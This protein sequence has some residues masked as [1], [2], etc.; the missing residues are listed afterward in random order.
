MPD[1]P[2]T[3]EP[4]THAGPAYAVPLPYGVWRWLV[5]PEPNLPNP[6]SGGMLHGVLRDDPPEQRPDSLFRADSRVFQHTLVRL[7]ASASPWLREILENRT[8]LMRAR[9]F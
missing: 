4:W 5:S 7:P 9:V 1:H 8:Q 2:Q 3:G 6:A